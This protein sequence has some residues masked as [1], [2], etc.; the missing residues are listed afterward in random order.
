[1]SPA[2]L[3]QLR[4]Q[5]SGQ[6]HQAMEVARNRLVL[7]TLLCVLAFAVLLLRMVDL[8]VLQYEP[9]SRSELAA[10][11]APKPARADLV[12]RSGAVLATSLKVHSLAVD[13]RLVQLPGPLAA[14]IVRIVPSLNQAWVERQLSAKGKF[15][16]IKR[17]LTPRQMQQLNALGEPALKFEQEYERFY[18]NGRLAAHVLGYTDP[19][20]RGLVGI[21]NFLNE[22]L[23]DPE[24]TATPMALS[25][26]GRVQHALH[27]EL[28]QQISKHSAVGGFGVVM[29][30]HTGEI[31]ALVSMPDFNPNTPRS[32]V[33]KAQFNMVTRGRYE[34]GST[35]KAFTVAQA[36]EEGTTTLGEPFDAT[37]GL[38]VAGFTINDFKPKKRWLTTTEVFIYSSNIGTARMADEFGPQRQ[39]AFLDK[40]GFTRPPSVELAE[41]FEPQLPNPWGRLAMMTV[42]YGHGMAVTPLNLAQG[43]S[44]LVN[45]GYLVRPTLLKDAPNRA[46]PERVI[47]QETSDT[48]RVLMRLAVREGTGGFADAEGYRVGG[49]TGTSEK[50]VGGAYAKRALLSSFAAVFPMD[51]PRYVVIVGLDEPKGTADTGGYATGGQVAAPVVGRF[52]QRAGP[53]LGVAPDPTRDIDPG[54]A[55]ATIRH[56]KHK[57]ELPRLA[58]SQP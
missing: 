54:L 28:A 7:L 36:L 25:I 5:L 47:S 17:K 35:F 3:R 22:R 18:P 15:R 49:K 48:M 14:E 44:A 45:G 32:D 39:R 37:R 57:P 6:R 23:A 13:P 20:G 24:A 31:R 16:W 58:G 29:D 27:D 41:V 19:D 43:L 52:I 1:M 51:A 30:V 50:V 46:A 12:D 21:E 53:L 33:L 40:L 4:I 10:I 11:A 34:L 26:D 38:R 2:V 9:R 55:L 8:A 56:L 42:A